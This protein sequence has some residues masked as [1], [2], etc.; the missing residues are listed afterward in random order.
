[1]VHD[2]IYIDI[3]SVGTGVLFCCRWVECLVNWILV[4]DVIL[5]LVLSYSVSL[6]ICCLVVN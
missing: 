2:M 1:M 4:S 3:C 6:L 5:S